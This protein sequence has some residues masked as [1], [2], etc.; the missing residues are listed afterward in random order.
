MKSSNYR[1]SINFSGILYA[2]VDIPKLRDMF[3][4]F[5]GSDELLSR[6]LWSSPGSFTDS[7][8]LV[9]RYPHLPP[10]S[11]F[12]S[13]SFPYTFFSPNFSRLSFPLPSHSS[14]LILSSLLSP[15]SSYLLF[16]LPSVP[17]CFVLLFS[18]FSFHLFT[19]HPLNHRRV[20]GRAVVPFASRNSSWP[21]ILLLLP[22]LLIRPDG[23]E[24]GGPAIRHRSARPFSISFS[25]YLYSIE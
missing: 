18:C 25:I 3:F 21:L 11:P 10:L 9:T 7:S 17:L 4:S 15:S 13:P 12:P 16:S 14:L 20:V 23:A 6:H 2:R 8:V 19:W 5:N 22:R 24:Y 1:A